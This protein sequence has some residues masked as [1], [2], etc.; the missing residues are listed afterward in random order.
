MKYL[1]LI[2]ILC[3]CASHESIFIV[4]ETAL[5]YVRKFEKIGNLQIK[6]L[7]VNVQKIDEPRLGECRPGHV[8][9][10]NLSID[11][12]YS[13]SYSSSEDRELLMFHELGHCILGRGHYP[14]TSSIM[15]KSFIGGE[16]YIRNYN[17][18]ISELF[19]I[20]YTEGYEDVLSSR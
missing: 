5:P 2:L 17:H 9:V 4:H 6:N 12:W 1:V 7:V 18:Y 14:D 3:S 15:F 16:N 10:I 20:I 19:G 11:D 13:D 8:P